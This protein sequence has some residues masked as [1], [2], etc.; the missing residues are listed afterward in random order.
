MEYNNSLYQNG[1]LRLLTETDYNKIIN[2][3]I[4]S[5]INNSIIYGSFIIPSREYEDIKIGRNFKYVYITSQRF[6]TWNDG[7]NAGCATILATSNDTSEIT[8]NFVTVSGSSSSSSIG[9][10]SF[11][12]INNTTFRFRLNYDTTATITF[13]YICFT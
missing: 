10:I 11:Q 2:T 3:E 13:R 12:M 5:M 7:A 8:N 4:P 6:Y 9:A 1:L